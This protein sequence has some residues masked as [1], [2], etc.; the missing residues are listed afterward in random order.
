MA[1]GYKGQVMT[2]VGYKGTVY[3]GVGYK[4]VDYSPIAAPAT[5]F[6]T[7]ITRADVLT[8]AEFVTITGT[9]PIRYRHMPDGTIIGDIMH[10]YAAAGV[11]ARTPIIRGVRANN[12]THIE[13]RCYNGDLTSR[14]GIDF[15][16]F[17]GWGGWAPINDATLNH[18]VYIIDVANQEWFA[19]S[20]SLKNTFSGGGSW[21]NWS[22]GLT[23]ESWAT[24]FANAGAGNTYWEAFRLDATPRT[25][26]AA[27]LDARTYVPTF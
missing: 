25:M 5:F 11:P 2:G 10:E 22:G 26:I 21:A 6:D 7:L 16:G 9:V 17:S 19:I 18:A 13:L 4:G 15:T 8:A 27:V 12:S 24:S 23:S 3:T 20:P 14:G 1:I